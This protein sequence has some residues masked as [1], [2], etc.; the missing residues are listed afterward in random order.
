MLELMSHMSI[1][2]LNMYEEIQIIN[3][4]PANSQGV[5]KSAKS[6]GVEQ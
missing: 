2:Y 5:E 6:Q 4:E 3:L 1:S